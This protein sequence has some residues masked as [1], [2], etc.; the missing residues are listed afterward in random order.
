MSGI[1]KDEKG[2]ALMMVMVLSA[3]ALVIMSSLLYMVTIGTQVSGGQKRYE[4][5][6]EAAEGGMEVAFEW[7]DVHTGEDFPEISGISFV[8]GVSDDCRQSKINRSTSDWGSDCDATLDIDINNS[9]TYDYKF[10]LGGYSVYAKIVNT[11]EGNSGPGGT[12]L[13]KTGVVSSNT[14]EVP[15]KQVSFLYTILIESRNASRPN[16]LAEKASYSLLYRY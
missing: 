8:N 1:I 4:T 15:V 10:D 16:S 7:V 11:V 6:Q 3:I 9:V 14:G 2:I 12:N 5:S 13:K